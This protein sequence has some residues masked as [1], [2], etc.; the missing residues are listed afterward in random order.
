MPFPVQ[1]P[2]RLRRNECFR[3]LVRETI[4][5][6]DDLIL[7]L[8]AI[9]G[10]GIKNPIESMPGQYQLSPDNVAKTARKAFDLGIPAVI[11]FG[12]PDDKDAVGSGAYAAGG[13]VQQA[14]KAVKNAVPELIV[15]TDVCLCEYTDHGHCGVI[16]GQSVD[17]DA[18]LSLLAQT[19]VSQVN[20]G[21]DMVA[22]SD[23]MD[24]RVAA[25]RTALDV[26]GFSQIPIM[27]YAAKY[28]SSYYGPFRSAVDSAPRFGDRRTYQMDP[29]NTDEAMREVAL[30]VAEGA[31]IIM[32]KPALA[33]LDIIHRVREAIDLPVAAYNVSGEYAMIKAAEK[34]G[35]ID[36]HRVML[37][38]LTAIKRAGADM[39][40]TYF[41][42][43][44]A[45]TL[46]E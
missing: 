22:P 28:C 37:E 40:L 4:L 5:T 16:A 25:I 34:L 35:W 26:D 3:R 45:R 43:D 21:A 30:D 10:T 8:F 12:I 14:V 36:G 42:L 46:N 17:N 15:I 24:G 33:F 39:I 1:R 38:T 19:A 7:P 29:A 2:R 41:A 9:G 11:L 18:T 13:I 20:A 32:V 6:P 44:A 27:A 23:M 31:D